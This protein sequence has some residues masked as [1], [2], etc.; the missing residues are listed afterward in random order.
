MARKVSCEPGNSISTKRH[1]KST[2]SRKR[3]FCTCE[4]PHGKPRHRDHRNQ[5]SAHPVCRTI[6]G[7]DRQD[8]NDNTYLLNQQKI[9]TSNSQTIQ[10]AVLSPALLVRARGTRVDTITPTCRASA[11]DAPARPSDQG[12]TA[13]PPTMGRESAKWAMTCGAECSTPCHAFDRCRDTVN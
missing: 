3:D 7:P 10:N 9:R 1:I 6:V 8:R 5:R 2:G 4:A 12:R 11:T 13:R